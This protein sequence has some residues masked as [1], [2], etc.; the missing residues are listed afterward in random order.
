ML[1]LCTTA[2]QL[3]SMALPHMFVCFLFYRN[4]FQ[5]ILHRDTLVKAFLD[6]VIV[7]FS[8]GTRTEVQCF[9]P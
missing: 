8:E 1:L 4:V 5:D 3:V 9:E 2:G 7:A 6:Q